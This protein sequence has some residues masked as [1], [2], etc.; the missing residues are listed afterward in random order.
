M[1]DSVIDEAIAIAGGPTALARL[2][3]IKM[4]SIY[5]W[6][7]VPASRVLAL[8]RETGIPRSRLR[9]DLYP[10]DEK[11]DGSPYGRAA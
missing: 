3:G 2:L 7:K 6:K 1:R 4:P 10:P 8:E 11:S 5:S 9:P